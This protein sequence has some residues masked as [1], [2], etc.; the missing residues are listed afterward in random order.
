MQNIQNIRNPSHFIDV[1]EPRDVWYEEIKRL[2]VKQ[3][4]QNDT[5]TARVEI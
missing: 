5:A 2:N 3:S 4:K 1:N